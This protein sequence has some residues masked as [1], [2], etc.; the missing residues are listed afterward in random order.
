MQWHNPSSDHQV[1]LVAGGMDNFRYSYIDTT[2]LLFPGKVNR[3]IANIR[4]SF[5]CKTA[6]LLLAGAYTW[7]SGPKLARKV[8]DARAINAGGTIYL[9]GGQYESTHYQDEVGAS[10]DTNISKHTHLK[11]H[12]FIFQIFKFNEDAQ[13]WDVVRKDISYS[14]AE[15]LNN[16]QYI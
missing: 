1:L 15:D 13:S 12:T 8:Q 4:S 3:K 2:E 16:T 6:S 10:D 14:S 5:L 9:V 7:S 11:Y